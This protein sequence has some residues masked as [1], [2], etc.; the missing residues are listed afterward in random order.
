MAGVVLGSLVTWFVLLPPDAPADPAGGA[1]AVSDG[2]ASESGPG[3]SRSAR[4]FVSRATGACL[5]HSLDQKLRTYACNGLSYQRWTVHKLPDGTHQLRNH[6]TGACLDHGETGL[7][8]VD[9][10]ASVTQ[11][12]TLTTRPDDSVELRSAATAACLDDSVA[13]GLRA[14]PCTRTSRQKWG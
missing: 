4:I 13:L 5:D 1:G 2:G 14:L 11:R 6:A 7:R 9:C 12:W 8:S 3:P 10:S